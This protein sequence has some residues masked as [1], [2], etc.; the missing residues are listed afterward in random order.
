[1]DTIAVLEVPHKLESESYVLKTDEVIAIKQV[2]TACT[3][4]LHYLF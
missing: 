4:V 2:G 3:S 1:M